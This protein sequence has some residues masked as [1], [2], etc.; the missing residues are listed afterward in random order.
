MYNK[1]YGGYLMKVIEKGRQTQTLSIMRVKCRRCNAELEI[2][3]ND[4][5]EHK[6]N[7]LSVS[8][9][10][11]CPECSGMN[12]LG[13][14]DLTEGIKIRFLGSRNLFKGFKK[15]FDK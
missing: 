4:L 6:N 8:Y 12:F 9:S 14:N 3:R 15:Q 5:K 13:F 11:T 10:Y 1:T 2:N 7:V